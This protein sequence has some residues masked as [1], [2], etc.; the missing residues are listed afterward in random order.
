MAGHS[1]AQVAAG[2]SYT[3]AIDTAGGLY[4][5]GANDDGQLANGAAWRA[6]PV[7]AR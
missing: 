3:C 1:W 5:W 2:Q 7:Q 4:C 6:A